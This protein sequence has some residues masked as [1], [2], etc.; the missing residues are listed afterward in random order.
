MTSAVISSGQRVG[1]VTT[2]LWL[3]SEQ[4]GRD[5]PK[6]SAPTANGPEQVTIF[7]GARLHEF[8]I[9]ENH[10]DFEKIVD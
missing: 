8:S 2:V 9:R 1:P 5:N 3:K 10:V 4:K 6:V 7:V